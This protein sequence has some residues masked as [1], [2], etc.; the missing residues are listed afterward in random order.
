[1]KNT[2]FNTLILLSFFI[3]SCDKNE[4]TVNLPSDTGIYAKWSAIS[5]R[6]KIYSGNTVFVDSTIS[7]SNFSLEFR[8]DNKVVRNSRNIVDTFRYSYI[9]GILTIYQ[10]ADTTVFDEVTSSATNLSLT[11]HFYEQ[12]PSRIDTGEYTLSFV[13]K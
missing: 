1:M 5:E 4:D 7:I 10:G 6:F 12:Q 2:L 13:K 11:V 8:T 9:N 3:V